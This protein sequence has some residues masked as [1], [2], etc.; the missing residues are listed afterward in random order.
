MLMLRRIAVG[1]LVAGIASFVMASV[2]DGGMGVC[3]PYGTAGVIL[4]FGVP[5]FVLGLLLIA[6]YGIIRLI[7]RVRD[8]PVG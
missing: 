1:L 6:V 7:H 8:N 3:G 5:A 4:M 2:T